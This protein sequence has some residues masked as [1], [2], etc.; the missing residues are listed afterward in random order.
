MP[1]RISYSEASNLNRIWGRRFASVQ[2]GT[3]AERNSFAE[4]GYV[5]LTENFPVGMQSLLETGFGSAR[6]IHQWAKE[7]PSLQVDGIDK[8]P[9]VVDAA[10]ERLAGEPSGHPA[11]LT[12]ICA[13]VFNIPYEDDT[14]CVVMSEGLV[15]HYRRDEQV[16]MVSE[17]S[18]VTSPGGRVIAAIPNF[19]CPSLIFAMAYNGVDWRNV[20]KYQNRWRYGYEQP[21]RHREACEIF[22]EAGLTNVTIDSGWGIWYGLKVYRWDFNSQQ[23]LYPRFRGV[24]LAAQRVLEQITRLVDPLTNNLLTTLFGYEFIVRGDKPI[25]PSPGPR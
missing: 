9:V 12:L 7:N 23:P 16:A 25:I 21:M 3:S 14:F 5:K 1:K 17:M 2:N 19:Y 11:N 6:F 20:A 24:M 4:Q 22:K 15:E 13:D 18:R 8:S 10:S